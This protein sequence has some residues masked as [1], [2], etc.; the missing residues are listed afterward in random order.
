ME[1]GKEGKG[2]DKAR[3]YIS[4]FFFKLLFS[5]NFEVCMFFVCKCLCVCMFCVC[6]GGGYVCECRCPWRPKTWGCFGSDV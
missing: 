3:E 4:L 1:G 2:K 6:V 5:Y